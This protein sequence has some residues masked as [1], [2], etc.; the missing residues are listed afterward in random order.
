MLGGRCVDIRTIEARPCPEG[1]EYAINTHGEAQCLCEE[2][3]VY[4]EASRRCFPPYQQGPCATGDSL[5]MV[6]SPEQGGSFDCS[7]ICS[8]WGSDGFVAMTPDCEQ[9]H[10]WSLHT[11]P[12]YGCYSCHKIGGLG[13]P[14]ASG[15]ELKLNKDSLQAFCERPLIVPVIHST[16]FFAGGVFCPGGKKHIHGSCRTPGFP[17]RRRARPGQGP[18]RSA[19]PG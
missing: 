6:S 18:R 9:I 15:K 4:H 3:K 12:H 17:A 14:C 19:F 16:V 5:Q 8:R 2:G 10:P 1:M 11:C 13:R 7:S